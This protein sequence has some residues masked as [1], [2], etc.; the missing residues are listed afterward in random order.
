MGLTN[1]EIS[2]RLEI[3]KSSATY[4]LRALEQTGYLRRERGTGKYRLGVKV[5]SL[6]RGV[7][8]GVDLREAARPVLKR[9]VERSG[10][11]AHLAVID[12]TD[13]VYI[14][15]VDSPGF[16]KM[17]TWVG[18]RMDV[19]STAVG[20]A[21][22]ANLPRAES[23]ALVK[24]RPLKKKAPKTITSHAA[25][26][27]DLERTRARGYALDD[28]ENSRGAR[29]VAAPV[30]DGFGKVVAAVGVSGTISQIDRASIRK[31]AEIVTEAAHEISKQ[32]GYSPTR[33]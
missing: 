12:Q 25:L 4:I 5:L 31:T 9:L 27:H 21:I 15:K 11:T 20:K 14:D 19:H 30:F 7:E 16:I 23:A 2:R 28:E 29:C 22:V 8:I 33:R 1:S 26:A 18:K 17:D 24:G 10:L 13:A 3:P 32:M 6:A